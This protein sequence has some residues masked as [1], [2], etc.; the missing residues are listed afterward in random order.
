MKPMGFPFLVVTIS[1][2]PTLLFLRCE[3]LCRYEKIFICSIL[4]MDCKVFL[5]IKLVRDETTS[6]TLFLKN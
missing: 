2:Q 5:F 3:K 1:V 6:E 4:P